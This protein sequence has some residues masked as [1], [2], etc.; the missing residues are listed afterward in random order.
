MP[1]DPE[2]PNSLSPA[3][4]NR[5]VAAGDVPERMRRRYYLDARGGAGLGFYV[6]AKVQAPAFRDRGRQLVAARVDPNAI[7]DMASIAQH[8]GWTIIT[9]RGSADFRRE[10]WLAGRTLGLEV[11]G[12]RPTERDLQ[13]LQRRLRPRERP[14]S[15]PQR[16]DDLGVR[17]R[18]AVVDAV[19]RSRV[20]DPVVQDRIVASARSRIAEW[21]ERGAR[22][23]VFPTSRER[24]APR[25]ERTLGRD[26]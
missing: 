21:L 14:G 9:A 15:G 25:G 10:A 16:S 26:R 7:R 23:D 20:R 5:S 4:R 11:H 8:R 12:H 19:V 22:F 2:T 3:V 1:A 6:D 17:S 18:L 13:E 24:G